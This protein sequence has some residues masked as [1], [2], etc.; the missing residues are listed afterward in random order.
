MIL[1]LKYFGIIAE[2]IAKHEESIDF[3]GESI[4]EL[5]AALK[6]N[7]FKLE[8]MNYTYAVNQELVG[9]DMEL[10]ENDKVAVLPP[11]SGG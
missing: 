10:K 9:M 8:V 2:T 7:Y 11:F 6:K 5:D 4:E 3:A 1:N